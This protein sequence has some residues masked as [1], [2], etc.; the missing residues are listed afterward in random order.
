MIDEAGETGGLSLTND[1]I[2]SS[3]AL[4]T[5]S[6][7][8]G[9][10]F[11]TLMQIPEHHVEPLKQVLRAERER[12]EK[13][14]REARQAKLEAEHWKGKFKKLMETKISAFLDTI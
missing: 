14:E 9:G 3:Q 2:E 11:E 13:A 6:S 12:A 1:I 7:P 4:Q 8:L 10:R 5:G